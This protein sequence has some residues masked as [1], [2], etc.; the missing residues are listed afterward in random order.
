MPTLFADEIR[1]L[2]LRSESIQRFMQDS[3]IFGDVWVAYAALADPQKSKRES[4]SDDER[5]DLLLYPHR[6]SSAAA[7]AEE[8][9]K[10]LAQELIEGSPVPK[11]RL[12]LN[13][14][15][16][17]VRL[18]FAELIRV[19]LPLTKWWQ[20]YVCKFA[21]IDE[22]ANEDSAEGES[23][24]DAESEVSAPTTME[25]II[26]L[27]DNPDVVQRLIQHLENP[28]APRHSDS[29]PYAISYDLIWMIR[30]VG[31][32]A[33]K[34]VEKRKTD[35]HTPTK[36]IEATRNLLN[37]AKQSDPLGFH[38]WSVSLN[39]QITISTSKSTATIKAD[40]ARLL[41][42]PKSNNLC[43]AVIDSGIDATH[44]AFRKFDETGVKK[45]PEFGPKTTKEQPTKKQSA[46]PKT[47]VHNSR[48]V[49][50]FDFTKFRELLEIPIVGTAEASSINPVDERK[51]KSTQD[52]LMNG[53]MLLWDQIASSIE[54]DY[55]T[56]GIENSIPKIQHGTHVAGILAADWRPG[57]KPGP[58]G[59]VLQGVCPDITLYDLRVVNERST[60]A[61]FNVLA[62]L[63]FIRFINSGKDQPVVHGVNISMSIP[64]DVANYAC[65]RTP[66]CDECDR[67]VGSGVVVVAAAGNLGYAQ[68]TTDLGLRSDGY[69]AVSITDPGNAELA[70]TVGATHRSHPH[71]YGV[72]YFSSRGP[73]GDGRAKPDIL[74]PGEKIMA[75]VPNGDAKALDGTSMAAPHVSGAAALLMARHPELIGRPADI[76]RILCST[77]TDLGRTRE[78]Q[79]AGML[80]VLR[81]LQSV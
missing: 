67:L 13:D 25:R 31:T 60:G 27:L 21:A 63:Q 35:K 4:E 36:L 19:A 62:A 40:A 45:L 74:A 32:I 48:V 6:D 41:F 34:V 8:I 9:R 24:S 66:I 38:L 70:I 49:K 43:W 23:E 50:T 10:R 58:P 54:V 81:A 26:A 56:N 65:G 20:Q 22:G 16:V 17:A 59:G 18:S 79:G 64:H 61:E 69:R 46:K 57:D 55:L 80:D 30:I 29:E 51:A 72:S 12:S 39:R 76:K 71:R 77:A 47:A 75:P 7:L 1:S 73:T 52:A 53:Q 14:T 3:P 33:R 44:I 68:F 28:D 15:H 78:F 2:M 11:Y 37:G 42:T 5:I